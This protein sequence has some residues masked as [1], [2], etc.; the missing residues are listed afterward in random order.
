MYLALIYNRKLW[1]VMKAFIER[2]SIDASC[3]LYFIHH[4]SLSK[5][6]LSALRDQGIFVG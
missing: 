4:F 2:F 3:F 6:A 5:R 1:E